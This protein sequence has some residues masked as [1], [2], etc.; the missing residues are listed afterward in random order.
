[1]CT[2]E[3]T[4]YGIN[5]KKQS[6]ILLDCKNEYF[7]RFGIIDEMYVIDKIVYILF[8]VINYLF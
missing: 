4:F 5:Y 1:M 3:V 2:P 6:V 8:Y 7:P